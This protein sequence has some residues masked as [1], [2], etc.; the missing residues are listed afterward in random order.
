MNRCLLFF[1]T[2]FAFAVAACSSSHDEPS[3]AAQ[4]AALSASGSA[5]VESPPVRTP[6]VDVVQALAKARA[7]GE[8]PDDVYDGPPMP[9]VPA[10]PLE[11]ACANDRVGPEWDAIRAKKAAAKVPAEEAE[12]RASPPGPARSTQIDAQRAFAARATEIDAALGKLPEGE[13][14]RAYQATKE[15]HFAKAG[16]R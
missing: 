1:S 13:R 6:H 3:V 15:A 10:P 12:R 11:P 5:R 4:S 16:V 8:G 7:P 2:V 14:A 9:P